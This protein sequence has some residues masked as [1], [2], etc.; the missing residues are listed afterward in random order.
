MNNPNNQEE[1][2]FIEYLKRGTLLLDQK[3]FDNYHFDVDINDTNC[4]ELS[5]LLVNE[6]INPQ[7]Y[8]LKIR[9]KAI[10][11]MEY[12]FTEEKKKELHDLLTFLETEYGNNEEA[13]RIVLASKLFIE[14]KNANHCY[15]PVAVARLLEDIYAKFN[16]SGI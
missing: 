7:N 8:E 14:D 9:P 6:G 4:K 3:D 16:M 13:K 11:I 10:K 1:E 15:L 2:I 5:D 12:A